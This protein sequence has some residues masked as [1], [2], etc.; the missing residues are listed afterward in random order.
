MPDPD[1]D[2]DGDHDIDLADLRRLVDRWLD[3]VCLG[4]G[5]VDLWPTEPGGEGASLDRIAPTRYGNDPNNWT[6]GPPSPGSANP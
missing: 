5:G 6:Q 2:I 1:G 4:P 3:P